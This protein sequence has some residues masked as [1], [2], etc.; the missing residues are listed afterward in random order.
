M[1]CR[2]CI[3]IRYVLENKR[4]G[5][6]ERISSITADGA[7]SMVRKYKGAIALTRKTNLLS[8]FKAYHCLLHQQSLFA[9]HITVVDGMTSAAKVMNYIRA[10]PFH[11]SE[12]RFLLDE[13]NNEYGDLLLHTEIRWLR[14]KKRFSEC[15]PLIPF[16]LKKKKKFLH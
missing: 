10:Q 13:Y 8:D 12:F 16:C 4:N 2:I 5:S 9:K 14:I 3:F 15:L 1:I 7:P 11:R 6:L